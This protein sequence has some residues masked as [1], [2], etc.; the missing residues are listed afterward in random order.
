MLILN[1]KRDE[2]I[3]IGDI[4]IHVI[5]IQRGRIRLG[6]QAPADVL[7]LR[8]ELLERVRPAEEEPK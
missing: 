8:G 4:V 7:V 3:V 6:I 2:T 5:E 1:R